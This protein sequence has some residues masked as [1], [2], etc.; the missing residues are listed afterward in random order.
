MKLDHMIDIIGLV[1]RWQ[2]LS[3]ASWHV[4]TGQQKLYDK[5]SH[6]AAQS[7]CQWV[8]EHHHLRNK[9][10]KRCKHAR[11]LAYRSAGLTAYILARESC[12]KDTINW[13]CSAKMGKTPARRKNIYSVSYIYIYVYTSPLTINQDTIYVYILTLRCVYIY[14]YTYILCLHVK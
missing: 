2:C 13:R 11:S 1:L 6:G 7:R 5:E 9:N 4:K 10:F 3:I 8:V 14:I 12:A